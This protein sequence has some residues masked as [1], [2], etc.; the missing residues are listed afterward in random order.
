MKQPKTSDLKL[1][2][3]LTNVRRAIIPPAFINERL[4]ENQTGSVSRAG[5]SSEKL[6]MR[7]FNSSPA[8]NANRNH[9]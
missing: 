9:F 2:G 1:V 5:V 7:A 3:Y 6:A 4:A 8:L